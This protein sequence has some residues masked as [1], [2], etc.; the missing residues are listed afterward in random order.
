[1]T[2]SRICVVGSESFPLTPEIGGQIIDELRRLD[3]EVI[4]TRGAKG[5]DTFLHRAASLIGIPVVLFPTSRERDNWSRDVEMVGAA[6]Q[7][8]GFVSPDSLAVEKMSGT[9]H[10]LEIGL[11]RKIP[12][13]A[14]TEVDGRLVWAGESE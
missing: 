1:M 6:D 10:C 5:F 2:T 11:N 3:P 8:L 14:F 7:V 13:K 9:Q 4:L 12:V